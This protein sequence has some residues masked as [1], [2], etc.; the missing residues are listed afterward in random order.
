MKSLPLLDCHGGRSFCLSDFPSKLYDFAGLKFDGLCFD[1]VAKCF[2]SGFVGLAETFGN[3]SNNRGQFKINTLFN[4]ITNILLQLDAVRTH[5]RLAVPPP[6]RR[7]LLTQ[8]HKL[9]QLL[10]NCLRELLAL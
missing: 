10:L 5:P 1:M 8:R 3:N 9:R 6:Q 2:P 4:R 7:H